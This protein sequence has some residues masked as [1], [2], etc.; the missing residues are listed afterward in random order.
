MAYQDLYTMQDE[1]QDPYGGSPSQEPQPGPAPA[2][3]RN[4]RD[5]IVNGII[6]PDFTAIAGRPPDEQEIEEGFDVYERFGGNQWR[7]GV[8]QRFPAA[9]GGNTLGTLA[10][11]GSYPGYG[12]PMRPDLSGL[13]TAPNFDWTPTTAE[14]LYADPSY[15][16]RLGEGEQALQQSAAAG[17]VLRTGG[18][19]KDIL[20]YGQ[21][22]ASQ[23]YG[24]VDARRF[25][26]ATATFTP[27]YD[28]WKMR[29]GT[30]ADA[31]KSAF[32]RA[33][34]AYQFG[35]NDAFRRSTFNAN[36]AFN[37]DDSLLKAGLP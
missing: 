36:D 9:G 32:D 26:D 24:N 6:I 27:K 8:Q 17:G 15:K 18:T 29:Y 13:P 19:L 20:K 23:E 10:I 30:E 31:A 11:P 2:P 35:A 12:G 33:W 16:F 37:R 7:A 5:E 22:F 14:D 34:E 3:T 4:R 21:N 28:A 25:R 1:Y